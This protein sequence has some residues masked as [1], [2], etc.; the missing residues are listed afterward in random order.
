MKSHDFAYSKAI[1]NA[2]ET[3]KIKVM[4]IQSR[5]AFENEWNYN[6]FLS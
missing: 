4:I 5:A 2:L 1:N 6:K 3:K